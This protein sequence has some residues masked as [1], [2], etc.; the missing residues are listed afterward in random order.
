[1]TKQGTP[2]RQTGLLDPHHLKIMA[3]LSVTTLEELDGLLRTEAPETR[4]LDQLMEG[5]DLVQLSAQVVQAAGGLIRL[6]EDNARL[7]SQDY[8]LGAAAPEPELQE[9][10]AALHV[11]P[12]AQAIPLESDLRSCLGA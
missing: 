9:A 4:V 6:P 8:G 1:M 5:T 7:L 2:I 12:P 11:E 3:A 10:P